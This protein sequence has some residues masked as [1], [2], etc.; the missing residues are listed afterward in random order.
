VA[1]NA[2]ADKGRK[3]LP[4]RARCGISRGILPANP[5][6]GAANAGGAELRQ[7]L[8]PSP[9]GK[10]QKAEAVGLIPVPA[11]FEPIQRLLQCIGNGFDAT[12]PQFR[13]RGIGRLRAS[14]AAEQNVEPG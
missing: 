5:S 8:A 11:V 4:E 1:E 7:D 3:E 13:G 9:A 6:P 12:P 14:Y 2:G 10:D